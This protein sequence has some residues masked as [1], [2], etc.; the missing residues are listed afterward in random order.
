MAVWMG[1]RH[2]GSPS[3]RERVVAVVLLAGFAT[4]LVIASAPRLTMGFGLGHDGFNATVWGGA[5]RTLRDDGLVASRLGAR[6]PDGNVY[7]NHPPA[8]IFETAISEAIIGEQRWATRLPAIVSSIMALVLV[9]WL[10]VESGCRPIAAAAGTIL[11]FGSAMFATYWS[12]LDTP[13]VG[14]PFGVLVAALWR[15]A[16]EGRGVR[17]AVAVAAGTCAVVSSWLG[18]IAVA[19][20]GAA[21]LLHRRARPFG[22]QLAAGGLVGGAAVIGWVAWSGGWEALTSQLG[23]RVGATDGDETV[24]M[25]EALTQTG[26]FWRDL[27]PPLT[28]P[29][30]LVAAVVARRHAAVSTALLFALVVA[31]WTVG[32]RH[33]AFVHEYWTYWALVPISVVF[34]AAIDTIDRHRAGP[35]RHRV[36]GPVAVS[37]AVLVGWHA[38][39]FPGAPAERSLDSSRLGERV[40]AALRST[41]QPVVWY[42]SPRPRGEHVFAYLGRRDVRTIVTVDALTR[43]AQQRPDDVVVAVFDTGD[44]VTTASELLER[45]DEGGRLVSASGAGSDSE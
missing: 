33:G 34:G 22:I 11:G 40:E 2:A 35:T 43:L 21:A 10:L 6:Q 23:A 15:R 31:T 36:A 42:V 4:C 32:F 25:L 30:L 24:T 16:T 27:F 28:V 41:D 18:A 12:M 1:D 20:F 45:L 38:I 44:A 37:V 17:S 39:V 14:L 9:A 7:A 19:V 13:V 26:R 29:V 3:R 8:I 5:S